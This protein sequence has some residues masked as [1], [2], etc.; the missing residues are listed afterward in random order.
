MDK[1]AYARAVM[2]NL[3][4]STIRE[5]HISAMRRVTLLGFSFGLSA[6]ALWALTTARHRVFLW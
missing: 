5:A 1:K 2:A 4:Q 3:Y 6:L